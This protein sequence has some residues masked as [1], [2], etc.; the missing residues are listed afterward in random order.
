MAL[1]GPSGLTPLRRNSTYDLRVA[2]SPSSL[3][4]ICSRSYFPANHCRFACVSFH[5]PVLF[6]PPTLPSILHTS[7]FVPHFPSQNPVEH[8][9]FRSLLQRTF[10]HPST[11]FSHVLPFPLAFPFPVLPIF[12]PTLHLQKS[13]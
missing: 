12:C 4:S 13:C 5:I 11:F 1:K 3:I 8:A 10:P 9:R 2:K 7:R 6:F